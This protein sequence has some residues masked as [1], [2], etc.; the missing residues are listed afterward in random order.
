MVRLNYSSLVETLPNSGGFDKIVCRHR[1]GELALRAFLLS[2]DIFRLKSIRSSCFYILESHVGYGT[3]RKPTSKLL[4]IL[5]LRI[6]S[7][8]P[9]SIISPMGV[10]AVKLW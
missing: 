7:S 10:N 4:R 6:S 3:S 8:E 9:T 2:N 1:Q 5:I